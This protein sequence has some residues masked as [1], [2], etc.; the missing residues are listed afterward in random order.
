VASAGLAVDR[1]GPGRPR[2]R[3]DAL[4][5]DKAYSSRANRE[6][7]RTKRVKAVIP[8]PADQIAHRQRRGTAGGR[9]HAFDATAYKGRNVVERSFN[10]H[11]QW[12]GLATRYDSPPPTEAASSYAQS[13]SGFANKETRPSR[14]AIVRSGTG[15][16]LWTR[17]RNDITD[18]FPDVAA[19]AA[20]QSPDGVA[21]DGELV[22]YLNGRLSFDGLQQRLV[23][24]PAKARAKAAE[25]PASYVAF[26]LLA[27][28]G[29]DLRTQ[30]WTTRRR[31][32]EELAAGWRPPLQLTDVTDDIEVAREWFDVLP[33]MGIEGL[34][35]KGARSRYTPGRR[36]AWKKV[37]SVGADSV[38][39]APR[40]HVVQG[41][42]AVWVLPAVRDRCRGRVVVG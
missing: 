31:R 28:A 24:G 3:P 40:E 1:L 12:R 7:L 14:I 21:L 19:A 23:T 26:D 20:E 33:A 10:D 38:R 42:A 4:L 2:T 30:P 25:L 5:G 32:I 39:A 15:A 41:Q 17:N 35:V 11:K 18:R 34:V 37:A 36:D 8:Q 16:R 29:V 13:H 6:L 27:I 22:I 9:P